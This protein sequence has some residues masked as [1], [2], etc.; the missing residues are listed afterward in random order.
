MTHQKFDVLESG[1]LNLPTDLP[2]LK[3]VNFPTNDSMIQ[4]LT[5][6]QEVYRD[7]SLARATTYLL[8]DIY[9]EEQI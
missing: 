2:T 9:L 3:S 5:K 4:M 6:M 7:P 8:D 1:S